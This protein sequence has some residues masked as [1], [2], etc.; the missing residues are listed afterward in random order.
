M[1]TTNTLLQCLGCRAISFRTVVSDFE[2]S[3][4]SDDGTDSWYVPEIITDYPSIIVGHKKLENTWRIPAVVGEIY[5]QSVKAIRDSSDILAGI[6][7]RATIEA[8][9]NDRDI[10]GRNLERRIDLLARHGLIA[11]KDAERLH[12]IR[13]LGN[14][15]AHEIK[16]A[17]SN[18]LIIALRVIEHLLVNLYILD[19][20]ADGHLDTIIIKFSSF[21]IFLNK[22]IKEIPSGEEVPLAKIFGRDV[23]RLHGYLNAHQ[24][25]LM[26]R[27]ADGSYNKLSIGKVAKYSGSRDQVQHFIVS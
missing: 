22:K 26:A 8:I 2:S 18:N 3:Y 25:D 5:T 14:D 19:S 13:F 1:E 6:G 11:Q 4:P 24:A 10:T 27:I 17:D 20:E 9:C 15:A 7:L 23:R 12:A 21:E 16:R